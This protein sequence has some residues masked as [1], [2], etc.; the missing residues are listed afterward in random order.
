MTVR[1]V[2]YDILRADPLLNGLGINSDSVFTSFSVDSPASR[3]ERWLMIRWGVAEAPVGRDTSTRPVSM[4]LWA[5]NRQRDYGPI[6]QILWRCRDLLLPVANVPLPSGGY[7]VAAD[8]S[9]SSEDLYDDVYQ[10]IMRGE[11][12]RVI[13]TSI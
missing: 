6:Q 8:W 10:A 2:V 4:A 11:T 3:L 7:L 5:Y 12:Y 13:A 9:F 1:Q